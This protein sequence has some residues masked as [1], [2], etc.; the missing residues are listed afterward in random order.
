MFENKFLSKRYLVKSR[1]ALIETLDCSHK[2]AIIEKAVSAYS[3][4]DLVLF[5]IKENGHTYVT[6]SSDGSEKSV[7]NFQFQFENIIIG[8][9][10]T[11]DGIEVV[12]NDSLTRMKW[13]KDWNID[14]RILIG[15]RNYEVEA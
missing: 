11:S 9:E 14:N 3:K 4:Y 6:N 10:E 2:R 13:G 7:N 12:V 8:L 15:S 1:K 5:V